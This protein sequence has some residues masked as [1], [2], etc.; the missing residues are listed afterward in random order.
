MTDEQLLQKLNAITR[1]VNSGGK[2][3]MSGEKKR[4]EL[5]REAHRRNLIGMPSKRKYRKV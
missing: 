3:G 5:V 1:E 2:V 4:A